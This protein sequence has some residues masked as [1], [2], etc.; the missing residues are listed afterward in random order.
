MSQSQ[1]IYNIPYIN[2]ESPN[3]E[4]AAAPSAPLLTRALLYL[5]QKCWGRKPLTKGAHVHLYLHTSEK[6]QNVDTRLCCFITTTDYGRP[7]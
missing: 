1:E 6:K 3:F 4:K 7:H 5:A 2:F